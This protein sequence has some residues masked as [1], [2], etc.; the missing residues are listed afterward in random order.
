MRKHEEKFAA[1]KRKS[2]NAFLKRL[3]RTALRVP[4]EYSNKTIG[5]L[6]SRCAKLRESKGG[7]IV[8]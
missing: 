6:H 4:E 7:H 8:E 5:D 1:S 3:W 2:R